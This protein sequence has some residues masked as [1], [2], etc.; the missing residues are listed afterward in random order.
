MGTQ[1]LQARI[2]IRLKQLNLTPT[3]ASRRVS[4]NHDL[5]R[6]VLRLEG[7]GSPRVDTVF[8]IAEA[9]ETSFVWLVTGEEGAATARAPTEGPLDRDRI[10]DAIIAALGFLKA[11]GREADPDTLAELVTGLYLGLEPREEDRPA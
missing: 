1:T 10:R 9:L 2:R 6:Q 5:F 8:R 4:E 3:A 7:N 11:Q